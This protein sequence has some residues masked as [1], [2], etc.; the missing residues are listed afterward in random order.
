MLKLRKILN[1]N[2]KNPKLGYISETFTD[3]PKKFDFTIAFNKET[4][5]RYFHKKL[6][7]FI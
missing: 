4:L 1:I 2:K 7:F 3:N 6:C 5:I